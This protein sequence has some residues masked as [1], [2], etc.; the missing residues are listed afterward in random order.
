[1]RTRAV[2]YC[3]DIV[4]SLD[5]PAD[6]HDRIR[7][8]PRGFE[9][10]A[11][12]AAAVNSAAGSRGANVALS[13]RCTVQKQNYRQLCATVRAAHEIGLSRISFLA[14]DVTTDAFN[15]PAGWDDEHVAQVA[16]SREDLPLLLQELDLLER[17][18]AEDFA[19]GFIAESPMKLRRRLHQYYAA[20]LGQG[21]FHPNACNAPVGLNRHRSRRYRKTLFLPASARQPVPGRE[22]EG[23]SELAASS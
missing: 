19:S 20:L 2:E 16:L 5:G 17:D 13:A 4:V 10:L 14:A 6:V 8:V 22:P 12:G 21:D 11:R 15:R 3:D 23:H 7:N 1:M 18:H 9:R